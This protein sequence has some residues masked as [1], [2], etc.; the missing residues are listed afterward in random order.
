MARILFTVWPFP[1][2]VHPNVAIGHALDER[3]HAAAFYTGGSLRASLE[4]EGFRV[5]PFECVDE[6]RVRDIVLTLDALSLDWTSATRRKALLREWLLETVDAQLADLT[7][8]VD[9]WRPDLLVCDPA[10]WGPLLVLHETLGLP[11]AV[12]SYVAACLLPG[13]EGPIVGVPLPRST[14]S[15]SRAIRR[16]LRA[17]ETIVAADFRRRADAVRIRYGLRPMRTSVTAFSGQMPLYL[18]PSTSLFD[19]QRSD[20]PRSVRYVGPCHW[21]RPSDVAPPPWLADLAR[22]RPLVYVTEGTM[23][24]KSAM[25]L[26]SAL[27]GLA[28]APVR[29]VATTGRHRDPATLELGV[30]PANARVERFVPHSDLFP[31]TDLVVTTGGTG[32][33]LSAL[34]AGIPLVVVPTAWDQPENAWRVVEAG[35]GVRIPANRCTPD[36]VRSAVERILGDPSFARNARRLSADFARYRGAAAAADLLEELVEHRGHQGGAS[37]RHASESARSAPADTVR[38]RRGPARR[39]PGET[40]GRSWR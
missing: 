22:D 14:G 11:L 27:Q 33:T 2:H 18:V 26:R 32:T 35:A 6:P 13:P 5:F 24:S 29:V 12:M 8:V 20:L 3:G 15:M 16:V 38:H 30:V 25:V 31:H 39:G 1:G 28:T 34:S 10:M 7:L 21:D 9:E 4:G 17:V 37:A 23:H 40:F 36:A 19:R